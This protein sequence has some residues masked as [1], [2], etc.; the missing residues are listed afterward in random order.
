MIQERNSRRG[1]T[2]SA[3]G[4]RDV[5]GRGQHLESLPNSHSVERSDDACGMNCAVTS[6]MRN[7]AHNRADNRRALQQVIAVGPHRD[8]P[9]DIVVDPLFSIHDTDALES[10]L[11][12]RAVTDR[13]MQIE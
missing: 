3:A 1:T 6:R 7:G 12:G 11:P 2:G 9:A 5:K 13:S 10:N 8:E 4:N